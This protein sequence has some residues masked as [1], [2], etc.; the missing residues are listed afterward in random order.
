[1]QGV[2]SQV[3]LTHS[4]TFPS[5]HSPPRTRVDWKNTVA[6]FVPATD[7]HTMFDAIVNTDS[8]DNM[9]K[10][11]NLRF[12]LA[13]TILMATLLRHDVHPLVIVCKR[14][15]V[16]GEDG[17]HVS[18]PPAA[19]GTETGQD[20]PDGPDGPDAPQSA[21][22]A[23]VQTEPV[24]Y[25]FCLTPSERLRDKGLTVP[26]NGPLTRVR[27]DQTYE[28]DPI[29]PQVTVVS[30]PEPGSD[31]ADEATEGS[32][33]G[34][35][36][37]AARR[38]P[39][40]VINLLDEFEACMRLVDKAYVKPVN[41]W[42]ARG[43]SSATTSTEHVFQMHQGPGGEQRLI[44]RSA[45][46]VWDLDL[47]DYVN[48]ERFRQCVGCMP[49]CINRMFHARK[50]PS[51]DDWNMV[52]VF[53]LGNIVQYAASEFPRIR[54]TAIQ[55]WSRL[56]NDSGL[57]GRGHVHY[58]TLDWYA[59]ER[60][61]ESTV[62][63]FMGLGRVPLPKSEV[64]PTLSHVLTVV[65]G[66]G[67]R[68][69]PVYGKLIG[70]AREKAS[71]AKANAEHLVVGGSSPSQR[72]PSSAHL[73][74]GRGLARTQG[75]S[76]G[77]GEAEADEAGDDDGDVFG[78]VQLG[79]NEEEAM[80][81]TPVASGLKPGQQEQQHGIAAVVS[82]GVVSE[83]PTCQPEF[84]AVMCH[85]AGFRRP[86]STDAW[87]LRDF[88]T[89]YAVMQFLEDQNQPRLS[90]IGHVHRLPSQRTRNTFT[91]R[92]SSVFEDVTMHGTV[93]NMMLY[94]RNINRL[95]V[96]LR[97]MQQD[98]PPRLLIML[99][100]LRANMTS[101]L[102]WPY[103]VIERAIDEDV[104]TWQNIPASLADYVD[105]GP[106]KKPR[107]SRD[108]FRFTR[109]YMARANPFFATNETIRVAMEY[110]ADG[111]RVRANPRDICACMLLTMVRLTLRELGPTELILGHT[112]AGKTTI[113]KI[114]NKVFAG[115]TMGG[116]MS[117]AYMKQ[118][119]ENFVLL[120]F[121]EIPKFLAVPSGGSGS[122][123]A[124]SKNTNVDSKRDEL[125]HMVDQDQDQSR[126]MFTRNEPLTEREQ[127]RTL[128]VFGNTNAMDGA[129]SRRSILYRLPLVDDFVTY[130]TCKTARDTKLGRIT[131][132]DSVRVAHLRVVN[133]LG[134]MLQLMHDSGGIERAQGLQNTNAINMLVDAVGE[135]YRSSRKH[136]TNAREK[137]D[138]MA[139]LVAYR[140]A[141]ETALF[142]VATDENVVSSFGFGDSNVFDCNRRRIKKLGRMWSSVDLSKEGVL[143]AVLAAAAPLTG[144]T[145]SDVLSAAVMC[146]PCMYPTNLVQ[147]V[148]SLRDHARID[149]EDVGGV[150]KN[151]HADKFLHPVS[152]HA[153]LFLLNS[154]SDRWLTS[155]LMS[156]LFTASEGVAYDHFTNTTLASELEEFMRDIGP[157][158]N[159]SR[160]SSFFTPFGPSSLRNHIR[161][162]VISRAARQRSAR[163]IVEREQASREERGFARI[164][165]TPS[166]EDVRQR[167]VLQHPLMR[168]WFFT[169][170]TDAAFAA[171][172]GLDPKFHTP[173]GI[174]PDEERFDGARGS[175]TGD[176]H[177]HDLLDPDRY[178]V[179]DVITS[180]A[181]RGKAD[182]SFLNAVLNEEAPAS[183]NKQTF[184][185]GA[186]IPTEHLAHFRSGQVSKLLSSLAMITNLLDDREF[187]RVYSAQEH[188]HCM[189]NAFAGRSIVCAHGLDLFQTLREEL[190]ENTFV[191][192][193]IKDLAAMTGIIHQIDT[194][195][196][197]VQ[198]HVAEIV[199]S[200]REDVTSIIA[201]EM[202]GE[203]AED[204]AAACAS[205][206]ESVARGAYT[207]ERA[208]HAV[209]QELLRVPLRLLRKVMRLWDD[210]S[211]TTTTRTANRSH[212]LLTV[213]NASRLVCVVGETSED[214]LAEH[215]G[216]PDYMHELGEEAS[217]ELF[218]AGAMARASSPVRVIHGTACLTNILALHQ[219]ST[220]ANAELKNVVHRNLRNYMFRYPD[221][222]CAVYRYFMRFVTSDMVQDGLSQYNLFEGKAFSMW[223]ERNTNNPL[224][225]SH[226]AADGGSPPPLC[227]IPVGHAVLNTWYS[228]SPAACNYIFT[229]VYPHS[230]RVL[231]GMANANPQPETGLVLYASKSDPFN[232]HSC[233]RVLFPVN[234]HDNDWVLLWNMAWSPKIT[235]K[236]SAVTDQRSY[237]VMQSRMKVHE[238]TEPP[239]SEKESV[240]D[241]DV[242]SK[243]NDLCYGASGGVGVLSKDT[244]PVR[245]MF[246]GELLDLV[247]TGKALSEGMAG[248]HEDHFE[249]EIHP[250][251]SLCPD[252][253]VDAGD[254]S[255]HK[256]MV[257][258]LADTLDKARN[259]EFDH[260]V[261]A[262]GMTTSSGS[263]AH[264]PDGAEDA[265]VMTMH[266]DEDNMTP[267]PMTPEEDAEDG[268][269]DDD[270]LSGTQPDENPSKRARTLG[271]LNMDDTAARAAEMDAIFDDPDS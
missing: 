198:I 19:D 166:I 104:V 80:P 47:T 226:N 34:R 158:E 232:L 248:S 64:Y 97:P 141:A 165:L 153:G 233:M 108:L 8:Y 54:G 224:S 60:R 221:I 203:P 181:S 131:E 199:Q 268:M 48:K 128:C 61:G 87:T 55:R 43:G 238:E 180:G 84:M 58:R 230:V 106:R 70:Q 91:R 134:A 173:T 258:L 22:G 122:G 7:E 154:R 40:R 100:M 260:L 79:E 5:V 227:E 200:I 201:D 72:R 234:P 168:P 41:M 174:T 228:V 218:D 46:G 251:D 186:G 237:H 146:E 263:L 139:R 45:G 33:G 249:V 217:E 69:P 66:L 113:R 179:S 26:M 271:S 259:G 67:D 171:L 177:G 245:N 162:G 17:V 205:A 210:R 116:D 222:A 123:T 160:R 110:V 24:G 269:Y 37:R 138:A 194:A 170:R 124:A 137:V 209:T 176:R 65:E 212:V 20:A 38:K 112:G 11:H 102:R 21:G 187:V 236:I 16:P 115:L 83:F 261:T 63:D 120:M 81:V 82:S 235:D 239:V 3:T 13:V 143:S 133:L 98:V 211:K 95:F 147:Y 195:L 29:V 247:Q 255:R 150:S 30:D 6:T 52:D 188:T 202:D 213:F 132:L 243:V 32:G 135:T 129:F 216:D 94:L 253:L 163:D 250:D 23:S 9:L 182:Q 130:D 164:E 270:E 59:Y 167:G 189:F 183:E 254:H 86:S 31:D 90:R 27:V 42:Q 118:Q 152:Q 151:D 50:M 89:F 185:V 126:N 193:P 68:L 109:E 96:M 157:A 39:E 229:G 125:L 127:G 172:S 28:G 240:W 103:Q 1:M 178:V 117:E 214:P 99:E 220:R 142:R 208:P 2:L 169:A 207:Q 223:A 256:S 262:A 75:S 244:C 219:T 215:R 121:D 119:V 35:G 15:C 159:D 266:S 49:F 241:P 206:A 107:H 242:A 4:T 252:D 144:V 257:E 74:E 53:L 264:M 12:C 56:Q 175:S 105:D 225:G 78:G 10:A 71:A 92:L 77:L 156:H 76:S 184:G 111:A 140:R 191:Y 101:A 93:C 155:A 246:D 204:V 51:D 267:E 85:V 57:Q 25:F 231:L 73:A 190:P 114:I 197:K 62:A 196:T 36:R 145:I 161:K 136:L 44:M 88:S 192:A 149:P 148:A 18:E 265:D 14:S